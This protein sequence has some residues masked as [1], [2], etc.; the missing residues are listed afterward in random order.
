[1]YKCNTLEI[2]LV[3]GYTERTIEETKYQKDLKWD[4]NNCNELFLWQKYNNYFLKV[5]NCELT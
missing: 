1:M 3:G 2:E 4:K 5:R